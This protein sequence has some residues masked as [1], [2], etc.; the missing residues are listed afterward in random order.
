MTRDIVAIHKDDTIDEALAKM[1]DNKV[2][3]LPV[4]DVDGCLQGIITE[5]DVLLKGQYLSS[6]E[7]A[8]PN[9]L[10]A[11][12]PGGVKEAQR[13]AQ[14]ELVED[15]MTKRVLTFMEDSLVVDIARAMIEH[16]V[17]RVPIVDGCKVV[18][19][20]S[21]R[22]VVKALAKE[23][24]ALSNYAEDDLKTGKILEL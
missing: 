4:L 7:Y 12:R 14:A 17:N 3:G 22:D 5:S 11:P 24:K 23:S 2:S 9:S 16:A 20:I 8:R 13:R 15:A 21:R 19:I 18:G 1:A 10:F 6:D